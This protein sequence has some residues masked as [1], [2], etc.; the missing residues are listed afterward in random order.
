MAD[1]YLERKME[2]LRRGRPAPRR[3]SGVAPGHVSVRLGA[4]RALV[5]GAEYKPFALRLS[6]A[7]CR[8]ALA[9]DTTMPPD[10]GLRLCSLT[11]G[12][13]LLDSL[14]NDWHGLDLLLIAAGSSLLV[15]LIERWC[16]HRAAWPHVSDYGGRLL[17]IYTSSDE[18]RSA[19][20]AARQLDGTAITATALSADM[21]ETDTLLWLAMP[22]AAILDNIVL[23]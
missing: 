6:R 2:E 14:L 18:A 20:A 3:T 7:G 5:V 19:L 13:P 22:Q 16:A 9:S 8:V 15:P 12:A 11:D 10:T 17:L 1:N 4:R 21:A 23:P